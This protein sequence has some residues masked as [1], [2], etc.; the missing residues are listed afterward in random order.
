MIC[1][2]SIL[3]YCCNN[4]KSVNST[5]L[6]STKIEKDSLIKSSTINIKIK[7]TIILG[8]KNFGKIETIKY[9]QDSIKRSLNDFRGVTVYLDILDDQSNFNQS[10]CDTFYQSSLDFVKVPV[11]FY[12]T[13]KTLGR[14]IIK[15]IVEEKII[16]DAYKFNDSSETR[17]IEFEH[18]FIKE[19]YVKD[20]IAKE[21]TRI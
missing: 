10:L 14:R 6:K 12:V 2:L 3:L 7:D 15:G 19:V 20:N 17:L 1:L 16:L 4:K 11:P 5:K 21:P 9:L 13:P 8:Q 18:F